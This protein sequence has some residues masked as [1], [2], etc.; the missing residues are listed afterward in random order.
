MKN[1]DQANSPPN[2]NKANYHYNTPIGFPIF[3]KKDAEHYHWLMH[4]VFSPRYRAG[5]SRQEF[6]KRI[7]DGYNDAIARNDSFLIE[8]WPKAEEMEYLLDWF[9]V[10]VRFSRSL[11]KQTKIYND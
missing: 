1:E 2:I 5:M 6:I 7:Q 11:P 3:E 8:K 9:A 4:A 10:H